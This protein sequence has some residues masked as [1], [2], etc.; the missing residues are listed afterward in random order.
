MPLAVAFLPFLSSSCRCSSSD[1]SSASTAVTPAA[2]AIVPLA[3]LL[4]LLLLMLLLREK[5]LDCRFNKFRRRCCSTFSNRKID[6]CSW[7][8]AAGPVLL[9]LLS[10]S[11]FQVQSGCVRAAIHLL[12]ELC[13]Y[14]SYPPT[15][16][17]LGPSTRVLHSH[18][19]NECENFTSAAEKCY[20]HIGV[21]KRIYL[22]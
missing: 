16:L 15:S 7:E 8:R 17:L 13:V 2:V 5:M 9:L 11:L 22:E 1:F 10:H 19:H 3:L 12:H 20:T 18:L 4:I 21:H 6:G 14:L